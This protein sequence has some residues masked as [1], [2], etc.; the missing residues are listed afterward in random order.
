M[1]CIANFLTRMLIREFTNYLHCS[2]EGIYMYKQTRRKTNHTM[3]LVSQDARQETS[4]KHF[5]VTTFM[6]GERQR[7]SETERDRR[8]RGRWV[9]CDTVRERK[10]KGREM[11]NSRDEVD[12]GRRR[13]RV[14]VARRH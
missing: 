4:S 5:T 9:A 2:Y 10:E 14:S 6:Q 11:N 13:G 7:P 1:R 12:V 8:K 3:S